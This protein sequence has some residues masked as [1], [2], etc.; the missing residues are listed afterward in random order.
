MLDKLLKDVVTITVGKQSEQI[1]D[2]LN[3]TKYVNEFTIAKKMDITINQA[4]NILYKISDFGL[5]SSERKKDKKKGWYT[6]YWRFE[7]LKALNF[8][9]DLLLK[10]K[11]EIILEINKRE[12]SRHY[13]CKLCNLEYDENEALFMDFTCDECG[14]LFEVKDD[15]KVIKDLMKSVERI[16]EKMGIIEEEIDKE[17]A[18]GEKKKAVI[19]KKEA[20]EK[21]KKKEDKKKLTKKKAVKKKAVKKTTKKKVI[22]KKVIKKKTTK[23]RAAKK[24]VKKAV[25]KKAAK[26]ST[27]KKTIKKTSVKKKAVK[28]K[29]AKKKTVKKKVVKK[30]TAK[31]KK[32]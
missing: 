21:E 31:K 3:S 5:V 30:K 8:L 24:P 13:I 2:L 9:K 16:N 19:A 4:R 18:K 10:E 15:V 20:K 14:E 32:K 29:T 27:S 6:Y 22:K 12:Q 7:I 17:I 1:A 25:K 28:K 23:K 26:K 11:E